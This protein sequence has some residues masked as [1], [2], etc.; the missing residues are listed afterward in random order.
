MAHFL[1]ETHRKYVCQHVF[2][3]VALFRNTVPG[4]WHDAFQ[5]NVDYILQRLLRT[6]RQEAGSRPN[7]VGVQEVIFE[8]R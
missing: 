1:S 8:L 5:L 7:A 2:P 3:G 6:S 4:K